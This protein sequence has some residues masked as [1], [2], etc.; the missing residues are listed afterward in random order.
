[1]E[2]LAHATTTPKN[3]RIK[4]KKSLVFMHVIEACDKN[5]KVIVNAMD[6]INIRQLEIDKNKTKFHDKTFKQHLKYLKEKDKKAYKM[7]KNMASVLI[8]LS[9]VMYHA[10][11]KDQTQMPLPINI[12]KLSFD[13]QPLLNNQDTNEN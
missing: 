3:I 7:N 4:R 9:F 10:F 1:M 13:E 11:I 5:S 6:H 2:Q 12:S 8:N